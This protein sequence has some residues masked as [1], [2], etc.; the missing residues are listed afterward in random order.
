MLNHSFQE[1]YSLQSY[2]IEYRI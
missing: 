2:F 1:V